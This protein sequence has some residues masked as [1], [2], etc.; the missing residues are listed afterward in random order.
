M[1]SAPVGKMPK[2]IADAASPTAMTLEGGDENAAIQC[3][4]SSARQPRN[5]FHFEG[6]RRAAGLFLASTDRWKRR[7]AKTRPRSLFVAAAA[8]W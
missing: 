1:R 7:V 4:L 3:I 6:N 8:V 2:S 5:L